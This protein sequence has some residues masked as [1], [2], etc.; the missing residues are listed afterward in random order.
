MRAYALDIPAGNAADDQPTPPLLWTAILQVMNY[1]DSIVKVTGIPARLI[2]GWSMKSKYQT[3]TKETLGDSSP[4]E[5]KA[6]ERLLLLSAMPDT[7]TA[8]KAGRLLSSCPE[9]EGKII[10][11]RGRIGE[12]SLSRLLG[13]P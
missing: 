2:K 10:V 13:V 4:D 8:A 3:V 1:S 12:K 9:K 5:I 7:A 6:A 11:T